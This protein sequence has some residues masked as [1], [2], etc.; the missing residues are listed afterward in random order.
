[1]NT[2]ECDLD[3]RFSTEDWPEPER[4]SV[5]RSLYERTIWSAD[6]EPL[7]EGPVYIDGQFRGL[8]GLGVAD[9]TCTA[10]RRARRTQAHLSDDYVLSIILCGSGTLSQR[11]REVTVGYGEALLTN[12]AEPSAS[13]TSGSRFMAFRVSAGAIAS[14]V[15]N[16]ADRAGRPIGH[17]TPALQLL[18]GYASM[19]HGSRAIA[20]PPAQQLAVQ[21]VCD[22]VALALGPNTEAKEIAT[23]RGAR[24]ARLAAIKADISKS[25]GDDLSIATVAA[26]HKLPL[27]YMQ[28]LF[29]SE[30][31]SFTDYVVE[32]RLRRAHVMLADPCQ[33]E[34]PISFVAF[35]TG[36]RS[37]P[38]FNRAFRGRFDA[39][40]SDVR[41]GA[42]DAS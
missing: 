30:G 15:P 10:T 5:V 17:R 4:R 38:Y 31:T 42:R 33:A 12:G 13:I 25:L 7:P 11:G 39:T 20:T 9:V 2:T 28:R 22:L 8:P 21:N 3:F 14:R 6:Y 34:R 1:M 16:V 18:T 23:A 35:E 32:Q 19:L 24:A 29:E 41:A 37:V 36:F 26:R 40:P 27:R